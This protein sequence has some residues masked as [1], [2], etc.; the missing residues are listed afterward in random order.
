MVS[1]CHDEKLMITNNAELYSTRGFLIEKLQQNGEL[2]WS[3]AL[4]DS[5]SVSTLPGEILGKSIYES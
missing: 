4:S 5:L 2:Q 1:L 3:N